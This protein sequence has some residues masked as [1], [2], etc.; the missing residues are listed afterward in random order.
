MKK[1]VLFIQG[2]G[3]GAYEEDNILAASLQDALGPEYQVLYPPMLN[4]KDP[5]D[6]AWIA[7]ISKE[8]TSVDGTVILIGHSAGG[9]VLLKYLLQESVEQPVAGVFLIAIPFWGPED[10]EDSTYTLREGFASQLPK[11]VPIFLYHSRDDEWVPFADLAIYA[12]RIP[13]ATIREFDGRGHQFN[14]DLSEVASD[15]AN[16]QGGTH[17]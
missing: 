6:K 2:A 8:L 4:E 16:L 11:G 12:E 13:Q 14:N 17:V 3:E 9:A 1:Q 15:I 7:Q 5:E 10:E